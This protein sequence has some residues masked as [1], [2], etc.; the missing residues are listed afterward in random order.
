MQVNGSLTEA[1]KSTGRRGTRPAPASRHLLPA[2]QPPWLILRRGTRP[3]G[4]EVHVSPGGGPDRDDAG[5]PPVDVEIPDDAREL[6]R[7]VQAYRREQRAE[8]RRRRSRRL[9]L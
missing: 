7:D 1:G 3:A 9:H 6:D 8:R 2:S 4:E 5:L